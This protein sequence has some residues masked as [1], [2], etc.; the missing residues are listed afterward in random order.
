MYSLFLNLFMQEQ[1]DK[2]NKKSFVISTSGKSSLLNCLARRPAAIV[3]PVAG[4]TRDAIETRLDLGGFPVVVVDTAGLREET[5]G[6]EIEREGI[7]R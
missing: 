5:S 1:I 3:S 6:D 2:L 7:R 4:T